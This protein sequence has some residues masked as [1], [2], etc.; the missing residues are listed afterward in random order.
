MCICGEGIHPANPLSTA[1]EKEIS[2][3]TLLLFFKENI[4]LGTKHEMLRAKFSEHQETNFPALYTGSDLVMRMVM[5]G[6]RSR[7][8]V[9]GHLRIERCHTTGNGLHVCDIKEICIPHFSA[10]SGKSFS[11]IPMGVLTTVVFKLRSHKDAD[12]FGQANAGGRGTPC[13]GG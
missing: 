5:G 12:C 9:L 10:P 2:R 6:A 4:L 11:K 1:V 7:R 8:V 13:K 3:K